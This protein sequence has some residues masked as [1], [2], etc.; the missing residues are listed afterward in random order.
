[1]EC[2][3]CKKIVS[4]IYNLK[5]HQKTKYCL[6]IQ[7]ELTKLSYNCPICNKLFNNKYNLNRH[8]QHCND[9]STEELKQLT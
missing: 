3:Y 6:K 5:R 1:M 8:I 2:K 9:I 4:S 7:E